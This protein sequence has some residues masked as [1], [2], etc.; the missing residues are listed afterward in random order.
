MKVKL[1]INAMFC[2]DVDVKVFDHRVIHRPLIG[3]TTV[4]IDKLLPWTGQDE[5]AEKIPEPTDAL[6]N[7]EIPPSIPENTQVESINSVV[8]C[9][10]TRY[11]SDSSC[12]FI[13][14]CYRP[15]FVFYIKL[16]RTTSSYRK[17]RHCSRSSA[18]KPASGREHRRGIISGFWGYPSLRTES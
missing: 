8:I 7:M 2:P 13:F 3:S 14:C 5:V 4:K 15:T 18:C 1:P 12:E 9:L 17:D 6:L 16:K 10:L 11:A